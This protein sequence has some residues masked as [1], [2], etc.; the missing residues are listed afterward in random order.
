MINS[1]DSRGKSINLQARQLSVKSMPL[2]C[3]YIITLAKSF[4]EL[5]S[6]SGLTYDK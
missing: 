3:T 5:S 4:Q 1:W 2:P 6:P